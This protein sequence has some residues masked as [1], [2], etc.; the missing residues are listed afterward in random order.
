MSLYFTGYDNPANPSRSDLIVS[1]TA[2]GLNFGYKDFTIE[3]W[4]FLQ[5]HY[6]TNDN[7][8]TYPHVFMSG[9]SDGPTNIGV[10]FQYYQFLYWE[11]G[12]Y[13]SFPL[14][15]YVKDQWVHFS[16]NRIY[17][18]WLAY[19]TT[20]IFMNGQQ[21]GQVQTRENINCAGYNLVIG[22]QSVNKYSGAA[23]QGY[24]TNF[25]ILNGLCLHEEGFIPPLQPRSVDKYTV[26]LLMGTE[27][28]GEIVPHIGGDQYI[29]GRRADFYGSA[30]GIYID[31]PYTTKNS[32][33]PLIN[34]NVYHCLNLPTNFNP[35]VPIPID[36]NIE[37]A[38]VK[39]SPLFSG[40]FYDA[41]LRRMNI[42][43]TKVEVPMS[44][45]NGYY[46][47]GEHENNSRNAA[48]RRARAGGANVPKKVTKVL[49][50]QRMFS[51]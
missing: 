23:F 11:N 31:S 12:V 27:N 2:P 24:L 41:V 10:S 4:Q 1:S 13:H 39:K 42:N 47:K 36:P 40:Q 32:P 51:N 25:L 48:L 17:Y 22:N 9:Y 34:S 16:I 18:P 8:D 49:T 14:P 30:S 15:F 35:A 21:I 50:A 20:R 37:I 28:I 44:W 46:V 7:T 19:N 43:T 33:N 29:T 45:A 6:N 3:W 5:K 38:R 26:L